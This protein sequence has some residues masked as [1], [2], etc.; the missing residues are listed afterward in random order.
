[1]DECLGKLREL[2]G[3]T[4]AQPDPALLQ[5]FSNNLDD[6][7]NISGAWGVIFDWVRDA[8]RRLA[9]NSFKPAEAA[10][11]LATWNRL[12]SILGVGVKE[13]VE[14]PAEITALIEARQAARKAKDFLPYRSGSP[15]SFCSQSAY[16]RCLSPGHICAR[17]EMV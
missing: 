6:D 3:N 9:K 13:E 15:H 4:S 5:S 12:D 2:A 16:R 11:A 14:V 10:S 8:N 7:L 17:W 1:M